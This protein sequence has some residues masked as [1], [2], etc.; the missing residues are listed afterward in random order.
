M[1]ISPTI[2][3]LHGRILSITGTDPAPNTEISETVP[4]RR[5]WRLLTVNFNL[6]TD[7]NTANRLTNLYIDDGA[8]KVW[9]LAAT[10]AQTAS[11]TKSHFY[12]PY[13]FSEEIIVGDFHRALPTLILG[14]G[15][16][17]R[18]TT[19]AMQAGDNYTAPQLLVEEW[20]DP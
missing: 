19:T 3:H 4:K 17:I 8:L 15:Y 2:H 14:P 11:Q 18:S 10:N 9:H 7:V 6:T 12:A 20:I 1:E 16:R 5:R 13:Q